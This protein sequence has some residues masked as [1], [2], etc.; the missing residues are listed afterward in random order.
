MKI[1]SG[2]EQR[3][4]IADI[5]IHPAYDPNT[6][7]SDLALIRL[8]RK[9]RI[10]NRVKTAC[11]PDHNTTFPIGKKCYITGWGHLKHY[12]KGPQVYAE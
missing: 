8:S 10:N 12:G 1:E 11:L 7:D 6:H 2:N 9:A 4:P 5:K 3:I